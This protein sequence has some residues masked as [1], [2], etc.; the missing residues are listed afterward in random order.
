MLHSEYLL[1]G[2]DRTLWVAEMNC[3]KRRYTLV[4]LEICSAKL[5]SQLTL[6]N[7]DKIADPQNKLNLYTDTDAL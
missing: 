1:I 6:L 4:D 3:F 2:H 5:C 7:N